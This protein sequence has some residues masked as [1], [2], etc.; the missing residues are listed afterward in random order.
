M[1]AKS[2]KTLDFLIKFFSSGFYAGYVSRLGGT[3][4]TVVGVTVY[5][6]MPESPYFYAG[7]IFILAIS[8]IWLSGKA[9]V[10][11]NKKDDQRIVIDEI[12]GYLIS[13]FLL[14]PKLIIITTAF[15]IFRFFDWIKPYPANRFQRLKGGLGVMGDDIMAG[16]Y[17]CV[18]LHVV[19]AIWVW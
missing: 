1:S 8:G 5:F 17:T 12:T 14:P 6:L 13:M 11:Y 9:E 18:C 4:G 2:G 7:L 19:N 10:I 16:I 3:L 15:V